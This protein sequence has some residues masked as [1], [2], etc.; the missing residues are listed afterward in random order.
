[1]ARFGFGNF[2]NKFWIRKDREQYFL[3]GI[4]IAST[5]AA[6]TASYWHFSDR[7]SLTQSEV[8]IKIGD[9]LNKTKEFERFR[10]QRIYVP[11]QTSG[12][13]YYST[14]QYVPLPEIPKKG[15]SDENENGR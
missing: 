6:F 2:R 14:E 7:I 15:E 10:E 1:M 8:K 5:I 4:I 13:K 3:S 12:R 11:A 9:D